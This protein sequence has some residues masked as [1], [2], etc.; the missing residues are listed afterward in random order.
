[1]RKNENY[2]KYNYQM[3]FDCLI[4]WNSSLNWYWCVSSRFQAILSC[5]CCR[6]AIGNLTAKYAREIYGMKWYEKKKGKIQIK[7]QSKSLS[8]IA[9]KKCLVSKRVQTSQTKPHCGR[10]T[11]DANDR[12]KNPNHIYRFWPIHRSEHSSQKNRKI[13]ED[14]SH[15]LWMKYRQL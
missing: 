14:F 2:Q 10:F 12:L 11:I 8:S 9:N 13:R 3:T 5:N 4:R 6:R 1:M 7:N 15:I